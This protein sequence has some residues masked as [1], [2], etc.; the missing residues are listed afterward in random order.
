MPRM[1]PIWVLIA[2]VAAVAGAT[3]AGTPGLAQDADD[4][5]ACA[6]APLLASPTAGATP[7]AV[8]ATEAQRPAWQTIELIDA[9]TGDAFTLADFAGRTVH[10]EL[11]AT[12]CPTCATQAEYVRRAHE[13]LT[14][15]DVVFVSLSVETDLD[16]EDLAAYAADAG[17]GWPFA[18]MSPEMLSAV[19]EDFGRSAALPPA[20]PHFLIR[21]DGSTTEL[22]TG[23]ANADDILEALAAVD[24][25]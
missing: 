15:D 1:G 6:T 21:P 2:L 25:G 22:E 12:W 7:P 14:G 16:R 4:P 5:Q 8:A 10:V 13:R 23:L 18:V 19:V 9:C 24:Q 20:T 17:L 3:G 11:M